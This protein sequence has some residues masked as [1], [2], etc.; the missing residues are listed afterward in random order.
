MDFILDFASKTWELFVEMSP[1]LILGIAIAGFLRIGLPRNLLYRHL[2]KPNLWS[3]F[4]ASLFG[5]P[6]PLCS[7]GIIPVAAHLKKEGASK[8]AVLSFLTSTPT[9]GVDSILATY[10]LMGPIF[11]IARPLIA[12]ISGLLNGIMLLLFD[13]DKNEYKESINSFNCTICDI[14]SPHTHTLGEK[15][16]HATHYSFSELIDDIGKWLVIGIVLGGLI[17]AIVP[18]DSVFARE[19]L[20]NPWISYV[21]M[22]VVGV[23]LYICSTGSIPVATSF[24]IVGVN[25][26]AV[27]A[28][29]IVGPAT[30]TATLTF[31]GGKFG[32]KTLFIYLFSILTVALASGLLIDFIYPELSAFAKEMHKHGDKIDYLGIVSAIVL[33][34][35]ILKSYV[36]KLMK[37]KKIIGVGKVYKIEDM[38]CNHCLNKILETARGIDGIKDININLNKRLVEIL[39]DYDE[40]TLLAKLKEAGYTPES[41]D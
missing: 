14:E 11:A 31:V 20:T 15:I 41:Q 17:S 27:L 5:V 21:F 22:I 29:L 8:P 4:K 39:G 38:T 16:K 12:L 32:R 7:C 3:V 6:L 13:K 28:F 36:S 33:I 25:P 10:A 26:G 19:Y 24:L 23:P 9:T 37:R 1:Y 18:T 40:P 2:S 30:N 35:L 34:L